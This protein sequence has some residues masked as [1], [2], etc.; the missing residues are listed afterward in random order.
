MCS[1]SRHLTT[2]RSR[3]A[4]KPGTQT[5]EWA[6]EVEKMAEL[7]GNFEL[8][9]E[10]RWPILL[11][12]LGA[13]LALHATALACMMYVPTVRDAF[14]IAALLS[15]TGYVDRP[16]QKTE[17][18]EDVRM[19]VLA[20]EK[21]RYP[22]GYF[23]LESQF[24]VPS[25]TRTPDPFTPKIISVAKREKAEASPTPAPSPLTSP[26]PSPSPLVAQS[27]PSPGEQADQAANG[28]EVEK[29]KGQ[30]ETQKEEA[31]KEEA[32]KKLEKTA[33]ANDVDL[34]AE[35]EI[36]KQ[37]L[38]DLA[39]YA[40]DLK[41][42]GKLN[43]NQIFE[44][45]VEAELDGTGR[46]RNPTFK[47][48]S[49]DPKLVDLAGRMIAALNDSG[50]LVYLKRLNEGKSSKVVF[51]IR[52]DENELVAKLESELGSEESARQKAGGFNL[53]L[54][55]GQKARE[56]KDE[57]IL[58]RNTV[59]SSNGKKLIFNFSMPRQAIGEMIKKQIASNTVTK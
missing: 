17:I 35:N 52:Q 12:L 45:A 39:I 16:Y 27:Q 53:L 40:N 54:A 46:L 29:T 32:Q 50:M 38:K 28:M 25:Q 2:Q 42:E 48:K 7:F 4:S 21:F 30:P 55:L 44:V 15:N 24:E 26:S 13:S 1:V 5:A 31:Q 10:P 22:N 47:Q 8:N 33:A 11:R 20:G 18:G 19:V 59:A 3:P 49:G 37:P 6:F 9:R 58:M 23:A 56:G 57:E 51:M 14:N 34:P 43:L 36:N 41:N